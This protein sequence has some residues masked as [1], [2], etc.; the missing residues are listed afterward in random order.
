MQLTAIFES[1]HIGD[2]NYPPLSR[3]MDV[4]LSFQLEPTEPLEAVS[5]S[6]SLAF[7]HT[8]NA[9]YRFV[10][11]VI[12]N[13]PRGDS[14]PIAVLDTGAFRF[15]IES[16]E[17][18]HLEVATRVQG[19][20]TLC[21]D[22]YIWVEFPDHYPDQPD[23]FYNLQVARITKV[24]IPER[25]VHRQEKGKSFPSRLVPTNLK[26]S[27]YE[28]LETMEGQRFDEEFYVIDFESVE[29]RS[30]PRTFHTL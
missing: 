27:D 21:L 28:Q 2:G 13:Y 22:Y 19:N 20:G 23:L 9:E 29:G 6:E 18:E 11:E 17:A 1:W 25:F 4:N 30:I 10:A 12:R 16:D 5:A 3:E 8:G 26:P 24:R 7:E 15:Y 14:P